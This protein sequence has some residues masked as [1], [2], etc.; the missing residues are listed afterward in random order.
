M[1]AL[2]NLYFHPLA[3]FPGPKIAAI[4]RLPLIRG[5]VFG[6]TWEFIE[7]WH[8]KYGPII[9]IAPEEITTVSPSAWK[10]IYT[11]RP[12]LPKD[13][14]SQTPPMNGADSLF[15]AAGDTHYRMR[16]TFA[17]AFS[18]K[19]LKDQTATIQTHT[20][21]FIGRMRREVMKNAE[22][23]LDIGKFYGTFIKA[24]TDGYL[25]LMNSKDTPL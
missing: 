25:L 8:H 22:G 4:T 14:F 16:K 18:D 13:P 5:A 2:Y 21:F 19:A 17:H 20:D 11:S 3:K 10:E 12:F 24:I 23:K 6:D 1:T 15:T 7:K 9:R